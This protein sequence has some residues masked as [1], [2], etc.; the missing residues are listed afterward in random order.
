MCAATKST[1]CYSPSEFAFAYHIATMKG[2]PRADLVRGNAF[3][4]VPVALE[5]FHQWIS[6]CEGTLAAHRGCSAD[7]TMSPT[8][9]HPSTRCDEPIASCETRTRRRSRA[10]L[11][12]L[13]LTHS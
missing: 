7:R 5:S 9:W 1:K 13:S 11:G 4:V 12:P 6:S 10:T 3:A 8:L 2:F